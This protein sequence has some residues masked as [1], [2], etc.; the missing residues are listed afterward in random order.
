MT[1]SAKET[2]SAATVGALLSSNRAERVLA[3]VA[4]VIAISLVV[5]KDS[6]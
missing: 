4:E 6:S 3:V 2:I 5:T 1:N